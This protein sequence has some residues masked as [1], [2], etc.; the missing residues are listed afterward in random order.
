MRV[1][2]IGAGAVGARAARQLGTTTS[3][4][5]VLVADSDHAKADRLAAALAPRVTAVRVD[6]LRGVDAV[7]LAL[8]SPHAELAESH[9][10]AGASASDDV[11]DVDALLRLG[12]IATRHD[13]R[14][15]VGA[16]FSPGMSGLLARY[17]AA[18]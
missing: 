6:E 5:E 3:N 14:L 16:A 4:I 7:V 15:V 17:A 8:P 2:V 13:R 11:A 18:R 1:G 9:L 12:P 10:E